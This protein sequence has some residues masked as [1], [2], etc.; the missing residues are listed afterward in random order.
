MP[1]R[2]VTLV[3]LIQAGC[4]RDPGQGRYLTS[5]I[6]H[7]MSSALCF[8]QSLNPQLIHGTIRP[9]F[10]VYR[11]KAFQLADI[12]LAKSVS[13]MYT[14]IGAGA[15]PTSS[16][17][18]DRAAQDTSKVDIYALGMV[19]VVCLTSSSDFQIQWLCGGDLDTW[20]LLAENV[21]SGQLTDFA[22]SLKTMLARNPSDRPDPRILMKEL[23]DY[24]E[25]DRE[26]NLWPAVD[27]IA[28]AE[29]T[30]RLRDGSVAAGD[31]SLGQASE[32]IDLVEFK[33]DSNNQPQHVPPWFTGTG[34]LPATFKCSST[35]S[36]FTALSAQSETE[37]FFLPP[38]LFSSHRAQMTKTK[39]WAT[40]LTMA[41]MPAVC[42]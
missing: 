18:F 4:F 11:N 26:R 20:R 12:S 14:E 22:P 19:I 3:D 16:N 25:R 2:A 40:A 39:T 31:E 37:A 9:D 15:E 17:P 35:C 28:A 33:S 29:E 8:L 23:G 21:I 13:D 42:W 1:L 32:V 10:V 36:F 6:I 24:I 34:S 30:D 7:G 41:V 5:R 27:N 38:G